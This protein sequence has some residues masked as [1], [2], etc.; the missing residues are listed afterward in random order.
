V[1]PK[2]TFIIKDETIFQVKEAVKSGFAKSMSSFV[3]NA[4]NNELENKVREYLQYFTNDSQVFY[5]TATLLKSLFY[6][7]NNQLDLAKQ[8]ALETLK[9]PRASAIIKEQA[10][11]IIAGISIKE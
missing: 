10:K 8:Y 3:E 9:L 2:T 7:K 5:A 4:L 6:L 11:A 1:S